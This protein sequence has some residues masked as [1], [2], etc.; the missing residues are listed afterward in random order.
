MYCCHNA[1]GMNDRKSQADLDF[2]LNKCEGVR[3]VQLLNLYNA[4]RNI[5][6]KMGDI[7]GTIKQLASQNIKNIEDIENACIWILDVNGQFN[8]Q[9]HETML[10]F[11]NV[12][13]L[14]KYT[15]EYGGKGK[16]VADKIKNSNAE[17]AAE[18]ERLCS[19]IVNKT[20]SVIT[21]SLSIE[22]NMNN[23]LADQEIIDDNINDKLASFKMLYSNNGGAIFFDVLDNMVRC[24]G[25]VKLLENTTKELTDMY[26]DVD[27]DCRNLMSII[28]EIR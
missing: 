28:G 10:A 4:V 24:A 25:F 13:K 17:K 6:K 11:E 7:V 20:E 21:K 22:V 15:K 5:T 3:N 27:A 8:N 19:E 12:I 14:H 9:N 2:L 26:N 18:I 1:V 16:T 23:I